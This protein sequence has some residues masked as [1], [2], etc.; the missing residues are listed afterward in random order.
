[1]GPVA[2]VHASTFPRSRDLITSSVTSRVASVYSAM[3]RDD[4]IEAPALTGGAV[5][6][7]DAE[8]QHAAAYRDARAAFEGADA[9][10]KLAVGVRA[11]PL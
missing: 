6:P 8:A 9:T 10:A 5:G 3:L 7:Q 2:Q 11:L 1:M 4:A